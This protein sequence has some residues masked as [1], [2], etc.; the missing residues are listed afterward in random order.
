MDKCAY[1]VPRPKVTSMSHITIQQ[2]YQ[3]QAL[4]T[5]GMSLSGIAL[6]LCK[7]KSVISRELKRNSSSDGKYDAEAAENSYRLRRK[8][9]V[10]PTKL[11]AAVIT[12]IEA[13]IKADKSP[14]QIHG[15]MLK[16]KKSFVISHETI[17]Q[18]VWKNKR[19]GGELYKHLRNKGR[20][21][22]KRGCLKKKRGVII[23]RIGIE[24]RP[25]VVNEKSRFGDLEIDLVIGKDH[26]APLL[27]IVD[28]KTGYAII[29]KLPS[30]AAE[31]TANTIIKTLKPI[32]DFIHTITSDNGKEFALHYLI[33]K[34]LNI[35]YYFANP[36]HS[37]ERGANENYNRLVRQYLPKKTDMRNINTKTIQSI[38]DKLNNRER[39]RLNFLSPI[40]YLCQI[41]L[42]SVA[43]QT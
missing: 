6:E 43:F 42:N 31:T 23:N 26:L 8:K 36:Y 12:Y 14:E 4:Q 5:N 28:R 10:K 29:K 2:R 1:I 40:Q 15:I 21:Y 35:Q 25:A 33:A 17:Y 24:N 13:G 7:N 20:K 9:S 34:E 16:E 19:Q 11:T 27:T 3:I 22:Q 18:Y 41:N 39:K 30:K 38:Q 37:W 32:K